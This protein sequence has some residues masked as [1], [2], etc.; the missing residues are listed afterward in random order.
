MKS[1]TA[2]HSF[3]RNKTPTRA[4]IPQGRSQLD[5]GGGGGAYIHIYIRVRRP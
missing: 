4:F 2:V 5:N 3:Y 1:L